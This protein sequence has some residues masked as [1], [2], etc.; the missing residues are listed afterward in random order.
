MFKDNKKGKA[1][2]DKKKSKEAD[3]FSSFLDDGD[4]EGGLFG[5]AGD[6]R[7]LDVAVT[8]RKF[9]AIFAVHWSYIF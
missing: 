9:R 2:E 3:I 5:G 8:F 7:T 6:V 4:D 1:V